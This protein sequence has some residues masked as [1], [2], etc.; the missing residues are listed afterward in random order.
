MEN[1]KQRPDLILGDYNLPNG[2]T[3]VEI[4]K[5]VR[6]DLDLDIR[7]VIL[8]GDISTGALRDIALHDCVQFSKPV[9]LRELTQ[10]ISKLLAKP[11][12]A[13]VDAPLVSPKSGVFV[14]DDDA[15]IRG[16]LCA[17]LE[18]EGHAVTA[19]RVARPF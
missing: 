5:R 4:S 8:T 16:A 13:P 1:T 6:R 9:K 10:A 12:A 3:G 14:V 11:P 2:L 15:Q 19:L 7:F 18:D 17:V